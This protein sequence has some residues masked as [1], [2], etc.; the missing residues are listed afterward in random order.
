MASHSP[1]A[2]RSRSTAPGSSVALSI[3]G[4]SRNG[5]PA[6]PSAGNSCSCSASRSRVAP[7]RWNSA[8]A[9][10]CQAADS[11]ET[12]SPARA[13]KSR[14]AQ[15]RRRTPMRHWC[16]CSGVP[17]P[18]ARSEALASTCSRQLPRIARNA[19][20]PDRPGCRNGRVALTARTGSSGRASRSPRSALLR[21]S[22]HRWCR[23]TQRAASAASA[24]GGPRSNSNSSSSTGAAPPAA[25]TSPSSRAISTSAPPATRTW[26]RVRRTSV[27]NT[28]TRL[29]S[30]P[31]GSTA[32]KAAAAGVPSWRAR[33]SAGG[34]W[35]AGKRASSSPRCITPS[36]RALTVCT[37]C[38]SSL[39]RRSARPAAASRRSGVSK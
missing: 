34:P 13:P 33:S 25:R 4:S 30:A 1:P 17:E 8:L 36:P 22:S 29:A 11:G 3:G 2:S 27:A 5:A 14:S 39:R 7:S 28:S 37:Q 19:C 20:P 12:S 10:A 21:T 9:C 32:R 15:R 16:R 26:R 31:S 6:A 23:A 38:P 24:G 18:A 35:P